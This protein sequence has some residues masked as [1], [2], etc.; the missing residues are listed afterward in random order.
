MS[1]IAA[2]RLWAVTRAPY[3]ASALFALRPIEH[4]DRPPG[5]SVDANWNVHLS[6]DLPTE[7]AGWWLIHHVS[8]LLRDHPARAHGQAWPL[9]SDAEVNDDLPR[10]A[11]PAVSPDA[12]GLPPG[13]LAERYL[14]LVDLIDVPP[15]LVACSAPPYTAPAVMTDVERS[16][17]VRAVAAEI[18]AT[19]GNTPGGWRRWAQEVLRPTVNWRTLLATLIRHGLTRATGR[20]DYS[21]A[22]PSRRS[23]PPVILPSLTRPT[24]RVA[25]VVDTSGSIREQTLRHVLA[26]VDGVL[27]A[28]AQVDVICCDAAAHP[29]QRVRRAADV[30]LM[31]GGGTDMREGLKAAAKLR[32]DLTIVLTDGETPWP[33]SRPRHPVV[34]CLLTPSPTSSSHSLTTSSPT[35]PGPTTPGLTDSG[36]TSPDSGSLPKW[37]HVV[38]VMT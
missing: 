32:P 4:P 33:T 11:F 36:L 38:Q 28:R 37:A 34:I 6:G 20:I 26:E 15:D 21:Y 30:T 10:P 8:H 17:L 18:D 7:E 25:V 14:E 22:R 1:A 3:L 19:R 31:G 29:P 9:A 12:L 16:L 5:V 24:P 27:R 13:L 35:T 23:V 2:A